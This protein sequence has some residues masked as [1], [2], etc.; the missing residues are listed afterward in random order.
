MIRKAVFPG[1]FDP[2]TIGH[3]AIVERALPLFDEIVIAIGENSNKKYL[4]TLEQRIEHLKQAF[5]KLN[6]VSIVS[7]S[8]LTVE[9]CKKINAQYI[10]RGLRNINDFE[11]EKAIAQM[12][13]SMENNIETIFIVT[14]P[15]YSAINSTIVRDILLHGGNVEDFLP[16]GV[17][18]K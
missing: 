9:F 18:L 6:K 10:L 15:K 4:F 8:G 14:E 5:G 2:I 3:Y 16:I 7:Y 13:K 11:Y 12:N 17:K 1:S